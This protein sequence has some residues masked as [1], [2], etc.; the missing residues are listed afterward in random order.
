MFNTVDKIAAYNRCVCVCRLQ[1]WEQFDFYL[2]PSL[3]PISK[4]L[5]QEEVD[6]FFWFINY[7]INSKRFTIWE[8]MVGNAP[9]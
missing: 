6:F 2:L 4:L 9:S 3:L 7:L 5:G 1:K 8:A